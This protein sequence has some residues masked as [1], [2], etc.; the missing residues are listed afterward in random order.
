VEPAVAL[1]TCPNACA[2]R[3]DGRGP[4][5]ARHSHADSS[6][7]ELA[8]FASKSIRDD[9]LLCLLDR[10]DRDQIRDFSLRI[11]EYEALRSARGI[12]PERAA[13]STAS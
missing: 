8:D 7:S 10:I 4:D 1:A 13:P 11:R 3:I 9:K 5:L 12:A 6:R 2:E